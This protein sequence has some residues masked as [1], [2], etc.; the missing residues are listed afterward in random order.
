MPNYHDIEI[1]FVRKAILNKQ[2]DVLRIT[3]VGEN[4]LRLIYTEWSDDGPTVDIMTYKTN[5]LIAYLY[6]V[7]WLLGLDEDPFESVQF[8]VPGYPSFIIPI[9]VVKENA[10]HLLDLVVATCSEWPRVGASSSTGA[11]VGPNLLFVRRPDQPAN[12]PNN[13]HGANGL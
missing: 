9:R 8:F 13:G 7:F 6:R 12:S 10:S 1:R 4:S 2:D 11:G 5:Q 3:H